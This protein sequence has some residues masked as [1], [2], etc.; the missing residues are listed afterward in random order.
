MK[1]KP[2]YN[3]Q[4]KVEPNLHLSFQFW[5]DKDLQ[6]D[7]GSDSATTKSY[8]AISS[9]PGAS[10]IPQQNIS[11]SD[12]ATAIQVSAN[13]CGSSDQTAAIRARNHNTGKHIKTLTLIEDWF[14]K[15]LSSNDPTLAS[16]RNLD[17]DHPTPT[18]HVVILFVVPQQSPTSHQVNCQWVCPQ[19]CHFFKKKSKLVRDDAACD[20]DIMSMMYQLNTAQTLLKTPFRVFFHQSIH[21]ILPDKRFHSSGWDALFI[22]VEHGDRIQASSI[23]GV[24]AHAKHFDVDK[25]AKLL[26]LRLLRLEDYN[27]W[28]ESIVWKLEKSFGCQ[29]PIEM[30]EFTFGKVTVGILNGL[31]TMVLHSS[32]TEKIMHL[33]YRKLSIG[34]PVYTSA[35]WLRT[36]ATLI[37]LFCYDPHQLLYMSSSPPPLPP[38][39]GY[40]QHQSAPAPN[41]YYQTVTPQPPPPQVSH[42]HSSTHSLRTDLFI[43]C[44]SSRPNLNI[45]DIS[46][47]QQQKCEVCG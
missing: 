42:H 5:S 11:A 7:S 25:D 4:F 23:G 28:I 45:S 43:S 37:A 9:T 1:K 41:V 12:Y 36:C 31:R 10:S 38:P 2:S 20:D 15:A 26:L 32:D 22:Q 34:M 40:Y 19:L 18:F 16:L 47:R 27:D 24:H 6:S 21:S 14:L 17:P 44:C 13:V 8:P 33:I 39:A 46:I 35:W 30:S 3:V 29:G